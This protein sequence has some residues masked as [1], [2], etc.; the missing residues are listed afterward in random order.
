MRLEAPEGDR[1]PVTFPVSARAP[2]A[3]TAAPGIQAG[4][5]NATIHATGTSVATAIAANRVGA[6]L[7]SIADL[8][9]TYGEEFPDEEFDPVFL[10]AALAHGARWDSAAHFIRQIQ[11][12]RGVD[13]K[14]RRELT[15]SFVGYGNA[16]A[17]PSLVSDDH[18]VTVFAA[19]AIGAGA[20]HAYRFPLPPSLSSQEL[21]RQVTVTLAWFTPINPYHRGYRR[22][23]L[24][25]EPGG[26]ERFEDFVGKRSEADFRAARRDLQHEVR[27]GTKATAFSPGD[28]LEF[29]VECRASAGLWTGAARYALLVTL[30]IPQYV[31]L[32]IYQEVLPLL[33]TRVAA[34][35]PRTG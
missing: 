28:E 26:L 35:R 7:D 18:R 16:E 24:A 10:K 6:L 22:A 27:R 31:R 32:P 34:P 3:R 1:R 30:E 20:A 2:G 4:E 5:L 17:R 9:I 29:T 11:E 33:R 23:Q 13:P 15:A 21:E 14:R 25:V 8:R 12:D 19:N